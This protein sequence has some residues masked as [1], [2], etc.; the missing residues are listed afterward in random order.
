MEEK[1]KAELPADKTTKP[2]DSAT[3]DRAGNVADHVISPDPDVRDEPSD[4]EIEGE[5]I[6][7]SSRSQVNE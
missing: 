6:K 1:D 3:M 5:M 7:K 4:T 2:A